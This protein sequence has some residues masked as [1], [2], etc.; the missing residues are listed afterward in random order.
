MILLVQFHIGFC[1]YVSV[2]PPMIFKGKSLT[3]ILPAI[4]LLSEN[5]LVGEGEVEAVVV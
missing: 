1:V 2:A 3:G 5:L 4:D